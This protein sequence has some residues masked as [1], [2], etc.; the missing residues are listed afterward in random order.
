MHN[1]SR[2]HKH[3]SLVSKKA[4]AEEILDNLA[5]G[6]VLYRPKHI[7]QSARKRHSIFNFSHLDSALQ[8]QFP[9][10]ANASMDETYDNKAAH[11]RPFVNK[12]SRLA[13]FD[14]T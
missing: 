9:T 8:T 7:E 2:V 11:R 4:T 13:A 3:S 10:T 12:Q 1:S 14:R 5:S 6:L